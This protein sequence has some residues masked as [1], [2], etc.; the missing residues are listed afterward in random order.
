MPKQTPTRAQSHAITHT[1]RPPTV[2]RCSATVSGARSGRR[3][4]VALPVISID[5]HVSCSPILPSRIAVATG[6]ASEYAEST[7]PLF[8]SKPAAVHDKPTPVQTVV[9]E[10]AVAL[11]A[12]QP[13]QLHEVSTRRELA[14]TCE[15]RATLRGRADVLFQ[16]REN[17]KAVAY[18]EGT[19]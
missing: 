2:A 11:A 18:G 12:Y 15:T 5:W 7:S 4:M 10:T 19:K 16:K 13:G 3:R 6:V 1:L 17:G 14:A 8:A 9:Q